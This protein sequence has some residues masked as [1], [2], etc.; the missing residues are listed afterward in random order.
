MS[1][2]NNRIAAIVDA[3]GLS[4][5]AF[6]KKINLSQQYISKIVREGTP[7]DRTISDICREFRVNEDWIRFGTEPMYMPTGGDDEFE[8]IAAEIGLSNDSFIK[9]VLRNYWRL[10]EKEKAVIRKLM[11]GLSED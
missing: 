3:S 7:S 5:A 10:D 8:E 11:D 2:I 1:N 6:G 9:N 4:R